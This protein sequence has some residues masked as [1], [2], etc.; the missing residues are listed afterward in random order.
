[1]GGCW[2]DWWA[3]CLRRI[4]QLREL[5]GRLTLVAPQDGIVLPPAKRQSRGSGRELAGWTGTPLDA[6]NRGG[7]IETGTLVC[8]VGEP[9]SIEAVAVVEQ[10]DAPLVQTG[11]KARVTASQWPG[12][13]MRGVI[14]DVARVD[15][16]ELPLHLVATGAIAQRTDMAGARRPLDTAYQVRIRLEEPPR[17]LLPGATGR[18]LIV[19]PPEPLAARVMRW[20]GR[21]FRFAK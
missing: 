5:I 4:A 12:G 9:G 2:N 14:E 7:F 21:T 15:A 19:A 20:L 8:L 16:E 6:E 17:A 11:R 13:A 1:M 3:C 18:A 10:A